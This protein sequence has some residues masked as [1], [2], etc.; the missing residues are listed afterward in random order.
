MK[1]VVLMIAASNKGNEW[2]KIMI[3]LFQ[4]CSYY[5]GVW[6]SISSFTINTVNLLLTELILLTLILILY[7]YTNKS[8]NR[9]ST[10]DT[11]TNTMNDGWR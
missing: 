3:I 2:M 6:L 10:I 4:W 7:K 8:I 5:N 9:I 11:I 1:L